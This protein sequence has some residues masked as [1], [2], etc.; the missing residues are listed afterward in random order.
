MW[1]VDQFWGDWPLLFSGF[2][3]GCLCLE[4]PG[5]IHGC[6]WDRDRF[7]IKVYEIAAEG[8]N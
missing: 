1:I 7:Y 3:R 6:V 8:V 4:L 2:K 5:D